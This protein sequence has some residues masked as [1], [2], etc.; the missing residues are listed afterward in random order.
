[1][2]IAAFLVLLKR[3]V[4]DRLMPISEVITMLKDSQFNKVVV[5]SVFL[6]CS[7]KKPMPNG[8]S[9][10][11]YIL[12]NRLLVNEETLNLSLKE[13][14]TIFSSPFINEN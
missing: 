8:G 6:Y 13:S 11:G 2:L 5:G 3:G 12:A 9:Q 7:L 4:Y 14:N 1:M 10:M